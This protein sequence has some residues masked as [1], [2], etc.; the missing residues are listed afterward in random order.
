MLHKLPRINDEMDECAARF[1]KSVES[2]LSYQV[3]NLVSKPK[4][5]LDQSDLSVG[6]QWDAVIRHALCR[7]I[8]MIA[9]CVPKYYRFKHRWCGLEWAAMDKLSDVRLPG[10]KFRAIIPVIVR[11]P[12]NLPAIVS[13]IQYRDISHMTLKGRRYYNTEEYREVIQAVVM[14]IEEVATAIA[15]RVAVSNCGAFEFPDVPAFA[16]EQISEQKDS[17]WSPTH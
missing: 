11:D 12:E 13:K 6:D 1:K 7:S 17:L 15:R 8:A 5:F 9:L 10:E 3:D 14:R 2:E 16:N 4:V